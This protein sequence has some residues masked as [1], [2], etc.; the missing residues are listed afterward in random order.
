[1][2][3]TSRAAAAATAGEVA[4]RYWQEAGLKRPSRLKPILAT[5]DRSL[6]VRKLGS[7]QPR[8]RAALQ[9]VLETILGD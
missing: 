6:V 7:L 3:V 5:L 4:F 1:M 2:A 9:R 8:D